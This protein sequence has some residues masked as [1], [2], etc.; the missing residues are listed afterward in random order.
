MQSLTIG[1]VA[2]QSGVGVE[3]VRFYE[4]RGLIDQPP[5]TDSGYRQYPEEA[6]QRIRF[7]KHAKMLGFSLKEIG[8]LLT[9]QSAPNATCADIQTRAEVKL[10]DINRR[11]EELV[12]MREVLTGLVK[13]CSRNMTTGECPILSVMKE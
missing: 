11:I 12:K 7:I 9:L 1:K 4:R 8:E 6:V 3:T 10:G 2:K 5:R 13:S